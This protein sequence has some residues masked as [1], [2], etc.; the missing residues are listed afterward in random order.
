MAEITERTV[1]ARAK[2]GAAP[3]TGPVMGEHLVQFLN[4]LP[5]TGDLVAWINGFREALRKLLLDVDRVA[6]R[7][8][9]NCILNPDERTGTPIVEI[10]QVAT[11][12]K[13]Q[14]DTTIST[15]PIG[16][17]RS[18]QMI[19][20]ISQM[21]NDLEEYQAPECFDYFTDGGSYLGTIILLRDRGKS[22]IS[23]RTVTLLRD[24]EPFIKFALSDLVTRHHYLRPTDRLFSLILAEVALESNLSTQDIRILALMLMGL[25]Y[26]QAADKMDLSI[27]TIRKHTKRIY[28]KTRTGSLPELFAKYFT[29]RLGIAALGEDDSL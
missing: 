24:L 6:V 22:T 8:N 2:A 11:D 14:S 26:K 10:S 3:A 9:I 23:E 5:M 29:P 18:R 7:V 1:S 15:T 12:A 21:G 13:R 27:D 16:L 4:A 20:D 19:E 17:N 25:S 28:R